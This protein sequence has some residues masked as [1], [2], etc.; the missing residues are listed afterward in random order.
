VPAEAPASVIAPNGVAFD[1]HA[2]E[3]IGAVMDPDFPKEPARQ[4]QDP[5]Q[6]GIGRMLAM[7]AAGAAMAALANAL[8]GPIVVRGAIAM[9]LILAAGYLVL[10][11]PYLYQQLTISIRDWR[12]LR[13]K[14]AALNAMAMERKQEIQKAKDSADRS[15]LPGS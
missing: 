9:L 15:S 8:G 6:F 14:R 7:L 2:K 13:K 10:R 12:R 1:L 4:N 11:T 3:M 5:F